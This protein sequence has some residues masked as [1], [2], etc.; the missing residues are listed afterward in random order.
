MNSINI[1]TLKPVMAPVVQHQ[2]A[3]PPFPFTMEKGVSTTQ[4]VPT[5]NT[6]RDAIEESRI[7]REEKVHHPMDNQRIAQIPT[8]TP[9]TCLPKGCHYSIGTTGLDC[10]NV[11]IDDNAIKQLSKCL[12]WEKITSI[13]LD[14]NHIT[15]VGAEILS[16]ALKKSLSLVQVSIADNQIGDKG[17]IALG[18]T[19]LSNRSVEQAGLI[20]GS[21]QISDKGAKGLSK[22]LQN[23]TSVQWVVLALDRT[24]IGDKG[25]K[26][27]ADALQ[28][29][30]S[31]SMNLYLSNN[32]IGDEGTKGLGKALQNGAWIMQLDLTYNQ[33]G[34][35]GAKGLGYALQSPKLNS[36]DV[37]G[38][39][40]GDK[41]A[42][43][44]CE[45]LQNNTSFWGFLNIAQNPMSKSACKELKQ[46]N[47]HCYVDCTV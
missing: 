11:G 2:T 44:L 34:D 4:R 8:P 40:I 9:Y 35:E 47:K 5:E 37:F 12:N 18:E 39:Q 23:N 32:Q 36:L 45:A 7:M 43:I 33:I 17:A 38:N 13:S 21:N 10:I 20:L 41:G 42:K 1:Q 14:Y 30:P 31:L 19:L 24:Q 16:E 3:N 29:N 46:A 15:D 27:L 22:V 26:A 6:Y 25:A 28:N